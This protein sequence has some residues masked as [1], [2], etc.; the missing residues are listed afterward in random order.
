MKKDNIRRY[1]F[2][3]IYPCFR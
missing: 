1:V 2:Y 3:T